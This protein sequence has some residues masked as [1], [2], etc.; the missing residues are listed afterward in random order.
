MKHTAWISLLP[1]VTFSCLIPLTAKAQVTPD[2]TTSTT[3]NQD[4][5]N[6]TINQGDRRGD[7]LFH[8]FD[9]FSVPTLGS[10]AFNN[11]NSIANIFSRVTGSSISN[12]DGLIS[13]N[14]AANLFLINP[15]GIIFGQNARLDLGGSFFASTADSLLF[16][17]DTEFS[18]VNPQAA[19]LLEVSI[20]IGANFRDNPSD[21]DN[22]ANVNGLKV[23]SGQNI[24]LLGGNLNFNGGQITAP[25][26]KVELGG[27]T[28]AGRVGITENGNLNF[29]EEV[30]RGDISFNNSSKVSVRSD[31]GGSINLNGKNI[32]FRDG[33]QLLAGIASSSEN[34]DA[35]AGDIIINGTGKISLQGEESEINNTTFGKGN[36]GNISIVSTSND[37][38]EGIEFITGDIFSTVEN[39]EEQGGQG[40]SGNIDISGNFLLL[41]DGAQI[42]SLVRG[43]DEEAETPKPFA[44]QGDA[45]NI[46]V[47][48]DGEV[49]IT[50]EDENSSFASVISSRVLEG[51][52]NAGDIT[53]NADS[54]II[55][56]REENQTRPNQILSSAAGT[57]TAG[58][59]RIN[60]SNEV[61]ITESNI[62]TEGNDGQI[63]IGNPNAEEPV[64]PS[65][66]TI[67]G[68]RSPEPDNIPDNTDDPRSDNIFSTTLSTINRGKDSESGLAGRIEIYAR[69]EINISGSRLDSNTDITDNPDIDNNFSTVILKVPQEN[70]E[71]KIVL[72]QAEIN[73]TND[74][75]GFA[76]DIVLN[77]PNSIEISDSQVLADG[78]RGRILIGESENSGETFSPQNV[79]IENFSSLST[80]NSYVTAEV[81][82]DT[83]INA[84]DISI[85]VNQDVLLSNNSTIRT[86]TSRLGDAG[87]VTLNAGNKIDFLEGSQISSETFANGNAGSVTIGGQGEN[88]LPDVSVDGF[89]VVP[90]IVPKQEGENLAVEQ[91]DNI[92]SSG[93]FSN[94]GAGGEGNAGDITINA[95]SLS[96]ANGAQIQT[97]VN[98][99]A[100]FKNKILNGNPISDELAQTLN[101]RFYNNTDG[102]SAGKGDAGSINLNINDSI[103]LSN[104]DNPNINENGFLTTEFNGNKILLSNIISS[105]VLFDAVGNG[106]NVTIEA[107]S[108]SINDYGIIS[109]ATSGT[110]N[111]GKLDIDV[112]GSITLTDLSSIRS[113]VESGGEG[114]AG[115][116]EIDAKSLNIETGGQIGSAVLRPNF[117]LSSLGG[118]IPAGKGK[119]A[120]ITIDVDEEINIS[121]I[122]PLS[123]IPAKELNLINLLTGTLPIVEAE[124]SGIFTS[125]ERGS[126]LLNDQ[127]TQAAGNIE[128]TADSLSVADGAIIDALTSNDGDGGNITVNANTLELTGG[129]QIITT[130]RGGG[131]AGNINLNIQN[132]LT[133]SGFDPNFQQRS[134][135]VTEL[136]NQAESEIPEDERS[137]FSDIINNQFVNEQKSDSGIFANTQANTS[138]KGGNISIG[139]FQLDENEQLILATDLFTKQIIVNDNASISASTNGKGKGGEITINTETLSLDRAGQI[140]S[141]TSGSGEGGTLTIT[142]TDLI[143]LNPSPEDEGLTAISAQTQNNA[144]AGDVTINTRKLTIQGQ[145]QIDSQAIEYEDENENQTSGT[146][147][148]V[149]IDVDELLTI[150]DGAEITVES[151]KGNAGNLTISATSLFQNN[152]EITAETGAEGDGANINLEIADIWTLKNESLVSANAEGTNGG[153][154]NINADINDSQLVLIAFP[155]TGQQGNDITANAK[156]DDGGRINIKAAGVFG[157][158]DIEDRDIS[159]ELDNSNSNSLN[160]FSATSD[161]G[162][163]GTIEIE[164][165]VDDPT[166]GLINLPASVGDASDQISQNPCEQGVGSQ[167]IITGKG[168]LPPTVSESLNSEAAQVNLIEPVPSGRRGDE[169][170]RGQGEQFDNPSTEAVPAQ[171]WVFNDKG[172]VT[173]TAYKTTNTEIKR[174]SQATSNSCS[175]PKNK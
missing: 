149:T 172:E 92:F 125:A 39:G 21:I 17:G 174:S 98:P 27:L 122:S 24:T 84:G 70:S 118:E 78:K 140:F 29:P 124:S 131:N 86:S 28:A 73:N 173:L 162:E 163:Q 56:E 137:P 82:E 170:T 108:L 164:N 18:A 53:I 81:L 9:E 128:I 102:L 80:T 94:V 42:Q 75:I 142:A 168:G 89:V 117:R 90:Q 152:S 76:G 159:P 79:R 49:K 57:G 1:L 55:E 127:Q 66:V 175:A 26:G 19:P 14:G 23:L 51:D 91:V 58:E 69:D 38:E 25:G 71:G 109:T 12:I 158:E 110:G 114:N 52:F 62:K 165:T 121:G 107:G 126:T 11:V 115:S 120:D 77:A 134:D 4:G 145:A 54:F 59:I 37:P 63:F 47:T 40:N 157:I 2:G 144:A 36:A 148:D 141:L 32:S 155:P 35:Q 119:A 60:A 104:T 139:V 30:A 64:I 45:G 95:S 129:G 93:I 136:I 138:G 31:G 8:S 156:G 34:V 99:P 6:F 132:S 135:R 16:E 50:G 65:K 67:K 123:D 113:T 41:E 103:T 68:T 10:A 171:G 15:N 116:I 151:P 46:I 101:E 85:D 87:S 72:N 7:N 20:P 100:T 96:L 112:D 97:Q 167:F 143:E 147:G 3:V 13:A 130:T 44:G 133:V 48:V 43:K 154:I 88:L 150:A 169:E 83:T 146:A 61:L 74:N 166:S 33:S 160:D 105:S 106:G 22:N 153:N 111:A 161:V 5:N